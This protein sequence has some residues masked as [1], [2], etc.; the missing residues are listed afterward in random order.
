MIHITGSIFHL[1]TIQPVL[2]HSVAGTYNFG[3][4]HL[5]DAS[6]HFLYRIA[7]KCKSADLHVITCHSTIDYYSETSLLSVSSQVEAHIIQFL[8]QKQRVIKVHYALQNNITS[9]RT[10]DLSNTH[11]LLRQLSSAQQHNI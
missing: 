2:P 8:R 11:N 3:L 4:K 7:V 5:E 1:G 6:L 9:I 10:R